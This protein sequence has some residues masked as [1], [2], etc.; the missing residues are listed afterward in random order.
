M[1]TFHVEI[2]DTFAGE[3][4]YCWVERYEVSAKNEA[5]A[6][7]KIANYRGSKPGWRQTANYGDSVRYDHKLAPICMFIECANPDNETQRV[8]I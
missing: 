2:T 7:R 1:Q 5:G 6:M 3:A 4:N 8:K